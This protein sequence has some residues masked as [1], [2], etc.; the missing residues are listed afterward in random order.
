MPNEIV[1]PILDSSGVEVVESHL[2]PKASFALDD[3]PAPT[4]KEEVWR[5]T[6][7]PRIA[8]LL[9]PKSNLAP[10]SL[11]WDNDGDAIDLAEFVDASS[12]PLSEAPSC[13]SPET[14]SRHSARS[15][16]IQISGAPAGVTFGSLSIADARA[17]GGQAPFD[18]IAAAA[19]NGASQGLSI[20]VPAGAV[21]DTPIVINAVGEGAPAYGRTR[22]SLGAEASATIVFDYSGLADY[23][24]YL[25]VTL[26]A[27]A[28]LAFVSIQDWDA[29]AVHGGQHSFLVGPGAELKSV[30]VTLGGDLV[31]LM[32]TVRYAGEGGH[33]E[34]FGVYFA[35]AGQHQEHRLFL[36]QNQPQTLSRVDYRGA[37]QGDGAHTV[38]VGDVLIR[39]N[40]HG[41]DS[42]EAN[43]NLI[44]TDGAR[45]DSVPNLEIETGNIVG[46]GHS[47]TTGRFD[48]EQLFYLMSRGISEPEARRLVVQGFFFDI[49]RRIG[50]TQVEEHLQASVNKELER[51]AEAEARTNASEQRSV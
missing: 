33:A 23:A 45:A 44:L 34:M 14:P 20:E 40:A 50:I 21:L 16:R 43:K 12:R 39:R 8:P 31:R 47:S 1:L 4:G 36:D 18:R 48:E 25:D 27:G 5:F 28:K 42:Y 32:E 30:T 17:A 29:G 13:P 37:L 10:L 49:I 6:P 24:E 26:G 9:D 3:H 22:I 38:W 51:A 15:R 19:F 41:I 2:H 7:L 46:A 11:T 35:D